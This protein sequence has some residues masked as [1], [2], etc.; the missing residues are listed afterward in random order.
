MRLLCLDR[1]GGDRAGD[2]T[3]QTNRLTGHFAETIF[4]FLKTAQGR[5]D[6]GDQLALA[7]ARAQLDAPVGFGR[8]AVI[9]V[10]FAQ[11]P[12]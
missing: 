2:Q 10:G 7:V 9:Q 8:G 11:R 4:A 3:A 1:H 6:L 12:S 5:V